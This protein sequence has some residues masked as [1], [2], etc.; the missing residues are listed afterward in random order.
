MVGAQGLQDQLERFG[1]VQ[2]TAPVIR[3]AVQFSP[4]KLAS[5][6]WNRSQYVIPCPG[7]RSVL[8]RSAPLSGSAYTMLPSGCVILILT[9]I[10][11]CAAALSGFPPTLL[12]V[13]SVTS[14]H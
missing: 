8:A 13:V 9:L 7:A 4:A 6:F 12:T 14:P 2:V 11:P 5:S 3:L 1:S 10:L